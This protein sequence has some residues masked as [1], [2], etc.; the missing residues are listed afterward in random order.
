MRDFIEIGDRTYV[1]LEEVAATRPHGKNGG[2]E[3]ISS[4]GCVLATVDRGDQG[5]NEDAL[6]ELASAIRYDKRG[7]SVTNNIYHAQPAPYRPGYPR[8]RVRPPTRLG[9]TS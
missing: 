5:K 9:G 6:E 3:V 1:D 8:P 4:R 2:F 7:E